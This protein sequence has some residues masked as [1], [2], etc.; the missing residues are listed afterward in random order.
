M[1]T[2]KAPILKLEFIAIQID[3]DTL[4]FDVHTLQG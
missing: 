1:V 4:E 3:T 2:S